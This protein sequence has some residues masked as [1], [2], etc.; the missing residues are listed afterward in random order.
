MR[1]RVNDETVERVVAAAG[2]ALEQG[3]VQYVLIGGVASSVLGRPRATDDIDVLVDPRDARRALEALD[4]GGFATE[5]TDPHWI[6]KGT[7]DGLTVD[8]MFNIKGDVHVD[9]EMLAHAR[10]VPFAG[11]EVPVAA[12][13]D[14]IVIKALA[15]DEPSSRHWYDALAIIT[16]QELD[17]DYLLRRARHGAHRLLSL[18][19]YAQ[20]N[21]LIVPEQ[22]IRALFDSIYGDGGTDGTSTRSPSS[23]AR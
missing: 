14:V 17:W 11:R 2:A 7:K 13:E 12:P 16:A 15:N 23:I 21:D 19:V 5:E 20:S 3:G 9:E 10:R 4:A 8:V 22:P 18:L 1:D 6:Y